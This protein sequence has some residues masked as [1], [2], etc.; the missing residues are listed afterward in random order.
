VTLTAS[1][2]ASYLWSTGETTQSI[3][4]TTSGNYS[5]TIT[6]ANGCTAASAATAVTVHPAAVAPSI[7]AGGPTTFCSGGSVTLTA[8]SAASYL[9]SNGATTQ[10]ITVTTS[11]NYSVTIT[12]VNGCT[13]ASAATSVV[14][15]PLPTASI[16][17]GG[18][19]TFC[20]GG[21]VTLTASNATSYLWS[22]GETTQSITASTSGNYSVTVT[23]GNSCSATSAATTVTVHPAAVTPTITAGG[24]TTFCS[25]GLVTLTAS[26][27]A[28]YLWSNGATTQSIT[29]T[30]SGNYSVT[31]T[32]ANGCTAAS[33]ATTVTVHP[34][35]VIPT[36]TAGGP[37]TF[38][39]GGS[40]TLTASSAAS[41]LWSNG[42]TTQSITVSASGN[43]SVTIT[44]ANGC[45]AASTATSVTVNPL[46]TASITAGGPT[47]FCSGGSVTLTASS[48]T[49]YLWSTGATTQ[50]ITVS[51]SGNYSVTVTNGNSC[52]ATS[53]VTTVTVHPA[54]VI[55]TIT[56]GGPTT[57][58]SGGSVTLTASSAASYLW[59]TGATSQSI[60]VTT[61]GNYSAT[62]TDA[63][64][65]T[66]TSA[67]T[68]V[69]V[70]PAAVMPTIT[71]GGPTTFCLGGSV[72]LTASS[73]A[74]YLWST[75]ETTQSITVSASGNY[76]VT[77][78][79]ANGCTAASAA[80]TVTV[81]P[82]AVVPTITAGGPTSFCSGGSVTLMASS[83]ASYLW[84]TGATSQSITVTAS[85]NYSVTITDA[86]GCTAASAATSVTV[87]PLPTASITA[88][89]PTTFCSGGSVTLTAS[90]AASYLW[91]TGETT[92]SIT[93]SAS[94][95]Y[96]VTIT[97]ANGCT[98]ASAAT[99]VTVNPLPTAS[100]TAG[101]P[102]TFC[103]GSLV[104]LTASSAAAYLWSTGETTQ[105][106]TVST[107]GNYSVTIIDGNSCSA[108]SAVTTVTVH[109]AAVTPTITAG[110]PTTFCSGGSVTL[111]AS[112]AASYLWSNGATTQSITVTTSGNYSVTITD[113]NGCTAASLATS[114]VVNPLP[115]ASITAGGLTTFC[116][117]GSV[118]LT[119][120]S[121]A[122]YLW[123]TGEITQSITVSTSGNYSVT[124]TDA[125]GCT[126]AS[127]ATSVV[128]NPLPTASITAG[129]PTTFCSG[130]SVTLTA[131]SAASYLWSSGETTQSITVSTSGSYS[132]TI[133]DA[134]GCT[135][136]STA[137]SVLV[138][139][140]PTASITAGGP[141]TF[142]SGGSVTLT[143]SSAASYLWSTG[144][145]TQ[146]ITVSASGNYSV[147][148][149][150]GNSCSATSAATTVTVHP[151]AVAPSI[152]AGGPTTFCSGG[153][154]TLTA[155]SAA[156]YLWSTGE[157]TQSI[158]VSTSGNYSVTITDAN[159][160]TAASAATSVVVNPLPTANITA[161][162]PTTFCSGGS[163]TLTASSAA[164]YL[165]STGETTQ[166]ITVSA[167]GNYSVTVTDVN[168]CIATS[169][170][171]SVTVH[172]AAVTPTITAVGPT[173]F[174]SGGSVTLT[175]SS[176]ASYL[177]S[178]GATTQSITV[179]ASGNYS[180]TIT[181]ANGCTATSTATSV[182]VSPLPTATITVSG[183]INFCAGGSVTLTA[184][185]AASY[186]WSTGETTQSI[187]ISASGSYSVTITD[188]NGCTATATQTITDP[189][190]MAL[191]ATSANSN[192]C[193]IPNGSINL[194][195]NGGVAPYTYQWSNN[196]ATQNLNSLSAGTYTVTV[197]DANGCTA[198][199]SRTITDP[200]GLSLGVAASN[201]TNCT[202]P[203]GSIVLTVNGGTAPFTY[204]WSHAATTQNVSGLSA[205]TYTVIVTDA[206][207]CTATISATVTDPAS[208]TLT[209]NSLN[210]TNCASPNGAI[211]ISVSG[212][213][214]P[215][216]FAWDNGATT[217]NLTGL[218][219][220][221]Y[222]VTVT[223]AG[224]CVATTSRTITDP[225]GITV[226]ANAINATDCQVANG[227]I[228]LSVSGGTTPYSYLWSNGVTT[229]NVSN[230]AAGNYSVTVTDANGCSATLS[231]TIT[232]PANTISLSASTVNSTSCAIPNG[233]ITLTVTGGTAPFTYQWNNG[234]MTQNL[235]GLAAGTYTVTV[236]DSTGCQATLTRTIIDPAGMTLTAS[237]SNATSCTAPDGSISLTV[238]GGV[239]PYTYQ[240]SNNATTQNISGLAAG[241]YSVTVIDA[242][243][244][245]ATLSRSLTDPAG[246]VLSAVATNV[247]D[248]TVPNGSIQLNVTGGVA[249]LTYL[250]SNGATTQ[251]L[252]DLAAGTYSVT[253]RDANGCQATLS[254]VIS[255]ANCNPTC[256][257]AAT[258][259]ATN[260]TSC[261]VANGSITLSVSGGS[262]PYTYSWSH[263][264]TTQNVSGL[265]AGNYTVTV[266][267]ANGCAVTLTQIITDPAG[268]GLT[269]SVVN[270]T[271]CVTPNGSI[272]LTVNGGTAPYSYLWSNGATTQNLSGLAAGTY[273][274]TVTDANGCTAT[275]TR[276]ITDPA[277]I[278]LSASASNS[279]SCTTP[280]GSITVSVAGGTAPF[281]YV[282]SNGAITKDLSDL[283]A[284]NYS[285]TVTDANGCSFSL[286]TTI[287]DPAGINLNA[288]TINSTNCT[289]P[290]GVINLTVSGGVA[291]YTYAWSNGA[292][293]QNLTG[294][295][296]GT[297]TL[298]VTDANGCKAT[299]SRTITD[300]SNIGLAATSVNSTSCTT[301]NGSINLTVTDGVAPFTY[302][303]SHGATTQNVSGLSAGTYTVTV[304]DA[305]GCQA[306]LVR[307]ITDP[308][309][310]SLA[311]SVINAT[312]CT[313]PNGSINLS[314]NGGAAPYTYLWSNGATTQN[315]TGLAAG[316]YFVTVTD[317]NG[318]QATLTRIITDP[319]GI[320]LTAS[321]VNSTNCA[322]PNGSINLTINGGVAP[323][324]YLWSNGATT[325]N[326]SNLAAG[327]YSVTVTDVNG[328]QANLTRIITDPAGIALSVV[329]ANSTDCAVP[330]G[331]L[332]L[333]VNGGQAPYNYLWSNGE[334]TQ[335]LT[336]L[337]AGNYTVTVRDANG[338]QAT[339]SRTIAD[340]NCTPTCTLAV[341]V[342]ATNSTSCT[343][344]DGSITLNVSG[345][346]TP[347]TYLWN[348]GASTQN[349]SGLAA[350][351]YTVTVRDASGCFVTVTQTITDPAG[352]TLSA[353]S[354]NSTDCAA[355][356]GSLTLT[357]NGGVTPYTYLWN[358]GATTADLS[359]LSAGTYSVT[360]RDANGCQATLSRTITDPNCTPACTM[361]ASAAG[362]NSTDCVTPNGSIAL[363]INGGTAPYTYLWNN[364]ETTQSLNGLSAGT[365][366]VTVRDAN[367]CTITSNAVTI[368]NPSTTTA[369]VS[370]SA[371][372]TT[373]CTGTA[374]TFTA[375]AANG[376]SAP[377]YQW[378]V[379]GINVNGATNAT[380]TSS[381]LSDNDQVSVVMTAGGTGANCVTGSPATSNSVAV[382]ISNSLTASVSISADQTTVCAGTSITFTATPT[383]GGSAPTYQWLV[384]GV[385]AGASATSATFTTSSLTNN[386]KVTVIMTAGGTGVG[387]ISGSPATSNQINITISNSL[388]ASVSITA[389]QTTGCTGTAITFTATPA[390]GGSAPTYQWRVNGVN[391]NG[392]TSATFTSSTLSNNDQVS[393][394]MTAGGTGLG[395]INGSPAT[396][397][398]VTVT[399][400][401]SLN[402]GVS[403]A[404][405]ASGPFCSGSSITFTATATNGGTTP[406]YQWKVNGVD[407]T[408]AIGA[409][410]TSSTLSNNDVVTVTMTPDVS[411]ANSCVN[412]AAATSNAVTISVKAAND[413]SCNC[414]LVAMPSSNPVNCQGDTNG[415]AIAFVLSGGSGQYLYSLNGGTPVSLDQ[416]LAVFRNQPFGA[417]SIQ[418]TDRNNTN[419]T[420]TVRGDIGALV[421]LIAQV[422][423]SDPTC[424]GNDGKIE[425]APFQT[426]N[427]GGRAPYQISID[428]G[429]TFTQT[430]TGAITFS[431]LT[432]GTYNV[433]VSDGTPCTTSFAV[434]LNAVSTQ[435]TPTVTIATPSP[436]VCTGQPVS[437]TASVSNGGNVPRYQWRVNGV[438]VAGATNATFT[439]STLTITDVVT[440]VMTPDLSG[441]GSCINP[442]PVSSNSLSVTP[443]NSLTP[444][445]GITTPNASVCSGAAVTF[446]A[447]PTNGG[448]NP[449]Y[450]WK[451]NGVNVSGANTATYTTSTL[452]GTDVVT[453]V[454]TPDVSGTGSCIQPGAVTSNGLNITISNSIAPTVSIAT[455][456]SQVCVGTSVTFTATANN[457]GNTPAYQWRVNGVNVS[458]ATNATFTSS[459]LTSTDVVTV[460][461]TPDQSGGN[462][463][464]NPA[465]V[466][467]NSLSV[468]VSSSLTAS[469]S[470]ATSATSICVGGTVTFTATAT[471]GGANPTYQW[472]INGVNV[473]G[474]TTA[475]FSSSTLNNNDQVTVA[476]TPDVSGT[477]SCVNP[478]AVNAT[479]VSITVKPANDPTCGCNLQV[480]AQTTNVKCEGGS[481]GEALVFVIQGGSGSYEYRVGN[482]AYQDTPNFTSLTA[483]TY[484]FTV[485]DKS[486]NCVG[487]TTVSLSTQFV[488]SGLIT[489]N[490]PTNC[491]DKGSIQFTTI[492]GTGTAPYQV[493]I[494]SIN[495]VPYATSPTP[496]TF[497][498]LDPGNY[499]TSIKDA[500]GCVFTVITTVDGVAPIIANVSK[501]D[502]KC[503]GASN[504]VVTI[505]S[506]S[507]G[508][509]NGYVYSMD[510]T[511]YSG[512]TSFTGLRAGSY[513]FYVKDANGTC[514]Q[515]FPVT[516]S[517]P[518]QMVATVNATQPASCQVSDGQITATVTSGGVAPFEYQLN[519][520]NFQTASTFTGLGNGTYTVTI[521]DAN[522]CVVTKQVSLTSA[523]AVTATATVISD[524]SCNR[525]D[526]SAQ[527]TNVTG[528]SGNY[529]YSKD[530]ITY[531]DSPLFSN[532]RSGNYLLI[533]RDKGVANG[534]TASYP[535]SISET[536]QVVA[537]VTATRMPGDCQTRDG[538]ITVSNVSGGQPAYQYSLDSLMNYQTSAV[539]SGLGNGNY[540]VYV[541]DSRGCLGVYSV[542]LTSPNAIAVGNAISVVSP[543][544]AGMQ[545]GRINMN[546]SGNNV[547]GGQP[548]YL[549]SLNGGAFQTSPLFSNLAAGAYQVKVKDQAG[550]ELSFGYTLT[551]PAGLNFEVVQTTSA[552]CGGE[553]GAVEVRNVG[554]GIAPYAYSINGIDFQAGA[555]FAN[556]TA[557]SYTMYVRDASLQTTCITSKTF[558]VLGSTKV[559]FDVSTTDIGCEGGDKGRI[560][561]KNIVG[562]VPAVGP[563]RYKVS[564]NGGQ[565][566]RD[567]TGD[568]L[569]FDN[570]RAGNYEVILTYGE[571]LGCSSTPRPVT[572][573][574]AGIF[575]E[576]KTTA[577]TCGEAN[578]KAEAVVPN[579]SANYSYSLEPNTGFRPSPIFTDLRPGVYTMYIRTGAVETCPNQMTFRVPGPAKLEYTFKKNNSCEG[580]KCQDSS[581]GSIVFSDIKG[582]VL[583]YKVSVD[584]GANFTYDIYQNNFSVTG[585]KPGD[586]QI[587][588]ADAAG[589]KT[590]AVPVKIEESRMRARLRVEPSM[591][592]EPTGKLWVQDIRGGTPLYEVSIDGFTW[593]PVKSALLDTTITGIGMGK[594]KL[595]V[596]DANGCIKCFDFTIEESKFVI[597]NIFTPNGDTYNDTFR[598]RNLPDGSVLSIVNRWGKVV[599]QTSSYQN[600]WDG[601]TLPDGIYYYTLN[602]PGK[603]P[604][605]GWVEIRRTE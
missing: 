422:N 442:A 499:K 130:G 163:V 253:V 547:T 414:S 475:T 154:V 343:I 275:L 42:A 24:P 28:S 339:L 435:I 256:T 348:N 211:A 176:A 76:S 386:D 584:N 476:M 358:T 184:S 201:S 11:G 284:G 112:N 507:G 249:P 577:A 561:I 297:Y 160:C 218:N 502:A 106:I 66:A 244:C 586:Y 529:E 120:N 153:S 152:T 59:S 570:L 451:V 450:Q 315:L 405:S 481:N 21:S 230:L 349:L 140:L 340:P 300:P 535:V 181:D 549:Y 216:S 117:G 97:D 193:T 55:P 576:V 70:H 131:S 237:V 432:A 224:G 429:R 316:T 506:P 497:N 281:T 3:T 469:V 493:S 605:T 23:D 500:N 558:N 389:D 511:N 58:C 206:G 220:G 40:V 213:I 508:A 286:T 327:A 427:G 4:V 439:S 379:N 557:G 72:T 509:N 39:S 381:T 64:G 525:A 36:I 342:S 374:I 552:G 245:T 463:C 532:L 156:S 82:A 114:V 452:T 155:S 360:V 461:M 167:S 498:G 98:A 113:A 78:T 397:N 598:I 45:T 602:V 238:N 538:E 410:F 171:T 52:S 43:Y 351:T 12:D 301:P 595:F 164:S 325:Q 305:N 468:T 411:G 590:M 219:G 48:A 488:V 308:A 222:T 41:Y 94:G 326:V 195:V 68:T 318:C 255:P 161:G 501:T 466:T 373:V 592:D 593:G 198:T 491:N 465:P 591:P 548:G 267:D 8:S 103:S 462:S 494:D 390:N 143:A 347:Y 376:G 320:T 102:T 146:S 137:T 75:G 384:N 169:A 259:S 234:A 192:S 356:N 229:Q 571:N 426:G 392:A 63:N 18:P 367:G 289:T 403:I 430:A 62:I 119:A 263:G 431:N 449:V 19:T 188:A 332:N 564:I 186:L 495:F 338:C 328:C 81:H 200:S 16:T 543:S 74:S 517:E 133:T 248:C 252:S 7:T 61:S 17:A 183:P 496:T 235:S 505:S 147:T 32:D 428:G 53:A 304:R 575:F 404:A 336:G 441:A 556:L 26:S 409:T 524:A 95:N 551:D 378:R 287:T 368:T 203:N 337:S 101:G 124:I 247:T 550:C 455:P 486:T 355:P 182:V 87:N 568:S 504:G 1:S 600:D 330:N 99:S 191:T 54:A 383:N 187:T 86:N 412:P 240:W 221:T 572:I 453:V 205:G 243:G 423:A 531:Q 228:T 209:A 157:T 522:N 290:N 261:T 178:T 421:T 533:V 346:T 503:F 472:K 126:A 540:K 512:T 302:V 231:R 258:A 268:I 483:G 437:F 197:T 521:R 359:G 312:S 573:A 365:Y 30:T 515:T 377:T 448:T 587:I 115:T 594:Y 144:E 14:V 88:G 149:T 214:A 434:K 34:A 310:I 83:A 473:A 311:A 293:T 136:A 226:T 329:S 257:L 292:I 398:A 10:S 262:A 361:T 227:S 172:P 385:S 530:G 513:T 569:V 159:G 123:S 391:V 47:T 121:A 518:A 363:T 9:W 313:S 291:P 542:T 246:I 566:F 335:N 38:C 208:I 125:N 20:A 471:N 539:F 210:S 79:D 408:G 199:L 111:T 177:W 217:Q 25:G 424:V 108:T 445:V 433:V 294:L 254:Q 583:P 580:D 554:G 285:V 457:G 283:S 438:N 478:A 317:A 395:C 418:I 46:P 33:A 264:A 477:N 413:P 288:S 180:V 387:C 151:A 15:N 579:A 371:S 128:V 492:T 202:T 334:T 69:T 599:Y 107:S 299:L 487:T 460:V 514:L 135:A 148:I 190:G 110:G 185:S 380:F 298:T 425:F 370:I 393:V 324:T 165:W 344:A 179:T 65:C 2:A 31:I 150:D 416:I 604:Y 585:L 574:S 563:A 145:T 215:Y 484:V 479:A 277:G 357:I 489:V 309:A 565:S 233:T 314:V 236:R 589:C 447:N 440:L 27:A 519:T 77:I 345:G 354:V 100:I 89:G 578:G 372:A 109:P 91:S 375:T 420:T 239:A 406:T 603:G 269:A 118:V 170:S 194:T 50:S 129:G 196:A 85:G 173:T 29:V 141:T 96:S 278:L 306:T 279:T 175:A 104:T 266:T 369:S 458:G 581:G 270:S 520:G 366:T 276:I 545:N 526:G 399:I 331:S 341:T 105:S 273:S 553:A 596:R 162:G 303:W 250:W 265:S 132:V 352:I 485:R 166:S 350:G 60:T 207:G 490:R 73:A 394:V 364:G 6:D 559:T 454:M 323:Y 419:C 22:T 90:S 527:I 84:S 382:S 464:I 44:D 516:V 35:A 56:A 37:T 251:N 446:T 174:C 122:S 546:T 407:V 138:S 544:C 467:S 333:T 388:T 67:A 158:T 436:T 470:V 415:E 480:A 362:T 139:P 51:A 296:N 510:G 93:V 567:V 223:D 601:G 295:A 536:L 232:A 321:V 396:S 241:T 280:N 92:Q 582:G 528:G 274:I 13:A 134:N 212:G 534:C 282:W 189:A 260:S 597:P 444:S 400:S 443:S 353:V 225:A 242:N 523:G 537:T 80:T 474:A 168:G 272:T 204:N 588:V 459:T 417:F 560:I 271:N 116:S 541:R 322:T 482:G 319:S 456:A 127:S 71:A 562:G 555:S 142:C 57:F 307:T 49:S 402:A 401:N 5:V